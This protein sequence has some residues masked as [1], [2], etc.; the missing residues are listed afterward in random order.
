MFYF[1]NVYI[2]VCVINTFAT[3]MEKICTKYIAQPTHI[4]TSR[5]HQNIPAD[6]YL[7]QSVSPKYPSRLI[8]EP[9]GFT[10]ISQPTHIWASRFH[11]NIPTDSYLSQSVSPKYPSRLI[12]EPVVFTKISQPT[13][14]WASRF[15]QNIP[16]GSNMSQYLSETDLLM[17]YWFNSETWNFPLGIF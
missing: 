16:D 15:H 2:I 13:H 5:F 7:S 4:W 8:S 12:S 9:V 3:A 14:I 17:K 1:C 10:K 11:Q 6:S